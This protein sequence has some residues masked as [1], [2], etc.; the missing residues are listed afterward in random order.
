MKFDENNC[1]AYFTRACFCIYALILGTLGAANA[2][3]NDQGNDHFRVSSSTFSNG[4]VLPIS[5]ISNI[6]SNGTNAC[7][8]DGSPGGN[9]SPEVSWR[10]A[11]WG[12][13]SFVVVMFDVTASF[14]HW[15]MYNIPARTNSLPASAGILGSTYGTQVY[16]DFY[17]QQYDGPCP[18]VNYPP[19]NHEYVVTVYALDRELNLPQSANFPPYAETLWYALVKAAEDGHVLAS[20]SITGFY[21]ATPPP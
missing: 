21:S 3:G 15:G 2:L 14:T 20:A 9:E 6:Q 8:V 12:T 13:R 10:D 17:D 11:P 5:T 1:A 7:S 18:P 19:N 16:N 4:G